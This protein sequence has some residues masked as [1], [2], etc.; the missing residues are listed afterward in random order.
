MWLCGGR[1]RGKTQTNCKLRA[2]TV[3]ISESEDGD[4]MF[5][6]EIIILLVSISAVTRICKWSCKRHGV[7]ADTSDI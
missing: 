1:G 3:S 6:H 7:G 5:I 2:R 4:Y